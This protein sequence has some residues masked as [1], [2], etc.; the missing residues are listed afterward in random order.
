MLKVD[1]LT[2]EVNEEGR[3][4][5]LVNH[6]SFEVKDGEMLVITGPNGGGKSTLAKV[7][8]GIEDANGGEIFLDEENITGYDID[9]RANAGIGYA[10]QQ[11]PRFK[12]MTV[13]KMLSLAAGKEL[14][15]AES[16][17][18]LSA[19]GLCSADYLNRQMD[20]TLSGGE[21]KRLEIAT[22]LA[23]PHKVSIFDEPEAG[24]DLWSFSMLIRRF[25]EIHKE[26]KECL[27]LISHQ[28]RIIQMADKIMVMYAGMVIEY[29][30]AREIF[31]DPKHPYTKGLLASIPRKDKDIDRLYTIEGTVPSLTS[32]PKG[33]RFCDRCTRAMEKCRNEQPPMYQFGE[34]SVRCFL[35]EAKGGVSHER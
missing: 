22:V 26:K 16:C 17:K 15:E 27:I 2:F 11:P 25:E 3:K 19:V 4:R 7:L 23:K 6:I 10:F 28:E 24:I 34:R 21:M 1:N 30:T 8:A 12:G 14:T 31:K 5:C 35:Y 32:M 29:A 20:G 18:L 9:H 33:C 13:K